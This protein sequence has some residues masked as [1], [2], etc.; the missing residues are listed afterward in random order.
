MTE[1]LAHFSFLSPR[2]SLDLPAYNCPQAELIGL[3]NA[4]RDDHGYDLLT[5]VT[6]I[7]HY[8]MSPRFE[9]VYHLY[10]TTKYTAIRLATPCADDNEPSCPTAVEIWP[11]ANWHERET[12]DLLGIRFEGHPD[13]RRILMWEDYPYHPLRK[14]FPLAGHEVELP[15]A[16]IAERTNTTVKPAPMMGGPFHSGQRGSMRDREPRADDESWTEELEKDAAQAQV[17]RPRELD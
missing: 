16:E 2:E 15:S 13:L 8:E 17:E 14:E 11:A 12:W 9:V 5:D 4:L 3:L 10:S 6:A 7:D 1:L